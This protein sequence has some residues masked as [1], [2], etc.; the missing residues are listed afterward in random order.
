MKKDAYAYLAM[1]DENNRY[2]LLQTFIATV[3]YFA[4]CRKETTMAD[5]RR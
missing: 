1:V 5:T 2:S 3:R 4:D